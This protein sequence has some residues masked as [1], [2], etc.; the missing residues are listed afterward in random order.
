MMKKLALAAAAAA[1]LLQLTG[2]ATTNGMAPEQRQQ[3]NAELSAAIANY[4]AL[5]QPRMAPPQPMMMTPTR[6]TCRQWGNTINC[7][8][9][10]A[11]IGDVKP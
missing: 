5:T 9:N 11:T 1:T 2:C 4:A 8:R 6:T 3:A 10:C 7:K